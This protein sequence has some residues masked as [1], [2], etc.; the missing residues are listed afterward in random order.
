MFPLSTLPLSLLP[1]FTEMSGP[2]VDLLVQYGLFALFLVFI[3]EGAKLLYFA[4]SEGLVPAAI[5]FLGAESL[6]E[7]AAI[8]GVAVAGATVGQFALFSLAKRKGRDYLMEKRWFR[9]SESTI[10]RFE[11]WFER[12]GP[13]AVPVSN[14]LPVVRG[15]L[16]VPAGFA[17]MDDRRFAALSALGTLSYEVIIAAIAVGLLGFF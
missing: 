3:L 10:A 7:Y 14:T 12:R 5:Y 4:P 8:I 16:I 11:G 13:I 15:L 17:E 1:D 6:P 2:A 9:V